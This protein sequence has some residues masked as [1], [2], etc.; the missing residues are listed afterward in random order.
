MNIREY[1]KSKLNDPWIGTELEGYKFIDNKQKGEVGEVYISN[2]METTYNSKVLPA[3]C[4]P[5][6]PYDR[7]IDGIK[8]EIKFSCAHSDNSA[9]VPTIKRNKS[10]EVNWTINHVAVEKCWERL[11]FCGINL[12]DGVVVPNI[13]WCTKQNFID[14]LNET[15]FYKSQQGGKN[16]NNDDFMSAGSSPL[17]WMQS[18]FSKDINEWN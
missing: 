13:V 12:I 8:T 15:T 7:I 2:Y 16:G 10:G 18:K 3:D 4:G 6:G 9:S 5:N 1:I 17:K 11:I 14:C